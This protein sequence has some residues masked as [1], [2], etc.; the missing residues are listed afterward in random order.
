MPN[1]LQTIRAAA[2]EAPRGPD[3]LYA[4]AVALWR[5]QRRDEAIQLMDEALRL[6]PDFAEAL[7]MG[8]Y[9]LSECGQ[10]QSAV[11]FY[12][13][14]LELDGSLVV[15]YVNLGKLLF[16]AERFTE[17]LA[18]F[19]TATMLAPHDPD[20]WC[21]R[22][23]TLRELGRLEESV[24]A[25]ERALALREDFP[26]A[27]INLGNALLKLDRSEEAF[28]AY[29]RASKPGPCLAKALLGQGLTLRSL[30][31]F[32]E[33]MIAFDHAAA[34]GSREAVAGKGCLM[35]T[36]GDFENGLE[37]YEAR[38]LQGKSIA[39]ALGTHF[40]SWKGP[41]REAKRV[42]VLND[43]GLGDTIQFF[44]YLPMMAAAG[45]DAT[46]VCPPRLR[47]LLSSK[48]N[49]RFVDSPPEEEPFDAQI[50]ISSLPRAFGTRLETI[51]A[52][53]PYLTA[54][55]A[56]REMWLK[57]I[58][59]QGFKIGVVWQGNSDP[60][61][62]RARSMPVTA[63]A[64]LTG[65]AGVRLISLQKG[66][67]EEQL[68]T[69]PPSFRIETLD[70]NFDAG[71]DAFVDTAAVMT[72][73]DLVVTCDT[74]VAHLAGALAVPV[75]VALKSDAEWRWLTGRA[76]SPWYPTMRLFRQRRRGVWS[77]VLEAMAGELAQLAERR[78]IPR[79]VSTPGSLGELI[80]KITI[81]RIKAERISQPEKLSNVHRELKLLERSA[82]EDGLSGPSIDLLTG[83]LAA[84]NERLW[85][86]EDALRACERERDF[87]PRFVALARS[88]YC[89]N[90][91]RA[92]IK[93][94]IN[95][96]ASSALVEE[97]SY[98]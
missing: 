56:L 14:A 81:L 29:L 93:R 71:P 89:E 39:E 86:I 13:R 6:K 92:A 80:D 15:G 78:A 52:A 28:G 25:A 38:W 27:A 33:A 50:A 67:G 82:R 76:D 46:F 18:S 84:V 3:A 77:D 59:A 58:G 69:L 10:A 53:V 87:G 61:A 96:L 57:R 41:E 63:L 20:A 26:E 72:C 23:G 64:P 55:P 24:E 43:H 73:L 35:L 79:M 90:D 94:A 66:A 51:P 65:I 37:G 49:V 12:R 7:C 16:A 21:S 95:T 31:R 1:A 11:R 68:S 5:E 22:A 8:G 40:P 4:A 98:A 91:T 62:D 88:V 45:V 60:E 48:A 70:A 85:T 44:R 83:Q 97:K 32:S 19:A 17:A 75:W 54:E 34:L 30:G 42:L 2:N 36:L 9:M 47:R 74:S